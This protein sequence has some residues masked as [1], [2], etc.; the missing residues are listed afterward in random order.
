MPYKQ[1]SQDSLTPQD[2]TNEAVLGK[3]VVLTGWLI[4]AMNNKYH[5]KII[6]EIIVL[7]LVTVTRE[8]FVLHKILFCDHRKL[9]GR[10]RASPNI[11]VLPHLCQVMVMCQQNIKTY[12]TQECNLFIQVFLNSFL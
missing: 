5:T 12:S 4:Q 10:S 11:S 6:S 1:E 8:G 3:R 9:I 2:S 7:K